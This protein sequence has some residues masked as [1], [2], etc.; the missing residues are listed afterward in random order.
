MKGSGKNA[1]RK[2]FYSNSEYEE[3]QRQTPD[4]RKWHT[5][6]YK[7]LGTSDSREAKEYFRDL[8]RHRIN[9]EAARPKALCGNGLFAGDEEA[10]EMAFGKL[11]AGK[12]K[13]WMENWET[14]EDTSGI[15]YGV[16]AMKYSDFV[17]KEL[18]ECVRSFSCRW[19]KR[20]VTSD[21][22]SSIQ[23]MCHWYH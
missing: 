7:G 6:Y 3:W 14:R 16:K 1:Q 13:K 8:E 11:N 20:V 2:Q 4:Y 17:N 23:N 18:I 9:F 10:I 12:R 21:V 22:E 19:Q 5:K 15:D